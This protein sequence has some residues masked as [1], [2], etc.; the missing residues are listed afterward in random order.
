MKRRVG[1]PKIGE[2]WEGTLRGLGDN[3]DDY[4]AKTTTDLALE[5]VKDI[6][7]VPRSNGGLVLLIVKSGGSVEI[8]FKP[9]G[10]IQSV[11]WDTE[12]GTNSADR[13]SL[14]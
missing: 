4:G 8:Y 12:L 7:V 10:E 14:R 2:D 1:A 13:Q 11:S 9:D 5:A 3:W 6:N